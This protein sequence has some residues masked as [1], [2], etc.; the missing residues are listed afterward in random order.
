M[1]FDVGAND[2]GEEV[3]ATGELRCDAEEMISDEAVPDHHDLAGAQRRA[4]PGGYRRSPDAP[5]RF[6]TFSVEAR[7]EARHG[8]SMSLRNK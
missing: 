4:R 3:H 2:V 5:H 6:A 1:P 8:L 7:N